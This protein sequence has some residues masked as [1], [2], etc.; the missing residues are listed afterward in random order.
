MKKFILLITLIQFV[1]HFV[2]CQQYIVQPAAGT[3]YNPSGPELE[4]SVHTKIFNH[5]KVTGY[6]AVVSQPMGYFNV[7]YP[8]LPNGTCGGYLNTTQV[9]AERGCLFATNAGPFVMHQPYG[10]PTCLGYIVANGTIAQ[11]DS[12]AN[13]NFGLTNDGSFV[14]GVLSTQQVLDMN[15]NQLVSG[16]GW[17]VQAGQNMVAT[18]G[19]EIAPRT[20]IATDPNG[21]LLIF[22]ADVCDYFFP[23]LFICLF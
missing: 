5:R 1:L 21:K 6:L 15:F 4:F 3:W 8:Q 16:F 20:A 2:D 22:E 10:Q 13:A 18:A 11:V 23:F 9:A 14:M 7:M 12:T 17:L 19:G